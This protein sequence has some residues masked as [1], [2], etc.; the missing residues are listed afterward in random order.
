MEAVP[1][2]NF[3][4]ACFSLLFSYIINNI[5]SYTSIKY[6]INTKN[7]LQLNFIKSIKKHFNQ[8]LIELCENTLKNKYSYNNTIIIPQTMNWILILKILKT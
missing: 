2:E 5:P 4:I 8:I 1:T 7:C 3:L 6:N